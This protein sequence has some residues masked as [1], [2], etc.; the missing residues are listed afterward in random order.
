MKKL[1]FITMVVLI[2]GLFLPDSSVTGASSSDSR[3]LRAGVAMRIVNPSKPAVPIGH[4]GTTSYLDVHADL[5]VQAMVVEDNAGHRLVW[6]GWDN[7][8][9][10]SKMTDEVKKIINDKYKIAPDAVCINASHTHSGPPLAKREAI[11]PEHFDAAHSAFIIEQ[12]VAVAGD[13]LAALT[14]AKLR[15][16][17]YLCTSVGINRRREVDG[18]MSMR[19]N[20]NGVVDHR[21]QII[22][23][24]SIGNRKLIGVVVKYAC[25]PVTVGPRGLG[26]D[27][28]GFMRQFFEKRHPGTVAVF[29]QGCGGDVRIQIID[30]EVIK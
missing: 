11:E 28:P 20:L 14:P 29:M 8:N 26:S 6:I 15:Y 1:R 18:R 22:A 21:T 2:W 7:C 30:D 3:V 25:H 24:E 4:E 27:Y 19:P 23:A 5:R 16:S 12:T 10:F 13:A 9:V 17:E